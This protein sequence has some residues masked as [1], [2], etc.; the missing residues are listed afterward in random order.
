MSRMILYARVSTDDNKQPE[1][2]G[3]QLE[4]MRAYCV[5]HGWEVTCEYQEEKSGKNMRRP[6][7][8]DA[9]RKLECKE[10]DGLM[11][12]DLSRL[13]RNVADTQILL[14]DYFGKDYGLVCI[15]QQVD[16]TT[17]IGRAMIGVMSVFSQMERERISDNVKKALKRKRANGVPYCRRVF[18]W[19]NIRGRMEEVPEEQACIRR[20]M[21]LA[22]KQMGFAEIT[23]TIQREGYKTAAQNDGK[24]TASWTPFTVKR[25]HEAEVKRRDEALEKENT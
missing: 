22:S 17:P 6:L 18:G 19:R 12:S 25:I 11:V 15:N 14:N 20:I 21:E 23:R 16:T 2:L 8:Q 24:S 10:A 13:S 4:R 9:L 3:R 1:S 5:V 7:L